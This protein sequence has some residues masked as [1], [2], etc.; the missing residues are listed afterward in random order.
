MWIE[1]ECGRALL[2]FLRC[3]GRPNE[4]EYAEESKMEPRSLSES[5]K[6]A[7]SV[8]FRFFSKSGHTR[9]PK[10]PSSGSSATLVKDELIRNILFFAIRSWSHTDLFPI[11]LL[12]ILSPKSRKSQTQGKST[13]W[14]SKQ[15]VRNAKPGRMRQ[16]TPIACEGFAR[17]CSFCRPNNW[18]DSPI[19]FQNLHSDARKVCDFPNNERGD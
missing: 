6:T 18:K 10:R 19:E 9:V 5:N 13:V 7:C 12:Q 4:Q 3:L 11:L 2:S 1:P 17:S 8:P 15:S 16:L 14:V